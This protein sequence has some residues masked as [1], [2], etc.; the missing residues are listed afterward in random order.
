LL[1]AV[2]DLRF[3]RSGILPTLSQKKEIVS[4]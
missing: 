3:D 4:S 1:P 2:V